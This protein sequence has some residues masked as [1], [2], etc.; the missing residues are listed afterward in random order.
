MCIYANLYRVMTSDVYIYGE[1]SLM[2][3]ENNILEFFCSVLEYGIFITSLMPRSLRKRH[4]KSQLK[5]STQDKI[6]VEFRLF[7]INN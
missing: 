1:L 2:I 7:F 3:Y 6:L 4:L 5:A